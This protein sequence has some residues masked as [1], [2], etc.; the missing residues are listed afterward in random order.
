MRIRTTK[1][2]QRPLALC[3]D[4]LGFV[5]PAANLGVEKIFLHL[6]VSVMLMGDAAICPPTK[7]QPL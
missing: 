7:G 1:D 2:I 6:K 4:A 3:V 5:L